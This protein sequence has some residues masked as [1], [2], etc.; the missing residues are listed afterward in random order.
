M[1]VEILGAICLAQPALS[2]R[3][4]FLRR[5]VEYLRSAG[6]RYELDQHLAEDIGARHYTVPV[7]SPANQGEWT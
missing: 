7:F 6:L 3:L 4:G 2:A 1:N 5:A